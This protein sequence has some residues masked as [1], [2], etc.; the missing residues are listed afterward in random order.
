MEKPK[1]TIH[2]TFIQVFFIK[3]YLKQYK[4]FGLI[5]YFLS[6]F[7]MRTINVHK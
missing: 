1:T 3:I 6:L 5:E 4:N 2:H 7:L